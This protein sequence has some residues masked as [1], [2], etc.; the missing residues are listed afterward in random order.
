MGGLVK[1]ANRRLVSHLGPGARKRIAGIMG[2]R[3]LA[4]YRR[5]RADVA[6]VSFPACGR[7]W[8]RVMVG[9]AFQLHY[10][11]PADADVVE[12]HHLAELD[13]CVPNVLVTHDDDAQWKRPDEI[14]RDK[15][16]YRRQRVVLLVRD[17]RDA[18]V[19][20]Y[21]HKTS[22]RGAYDGTLA[23]FLDEP[24]G[25]VASLLAFYDAWAASLDVP[26]ATLVVRY[27][28][29]HA[30]PHEQLRR[31]LAFAGVTGA[32]DATVEAAVEY[33]SFANMRRMEEAGSVASEKLR[34]VRAGDPGSY[35]TRRGTVG[36]HREELTPEQIAH[37]DRLVAASQ[38]S[39]FG[40]GTAGP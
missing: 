38:A 3:A 23:E 1:A 37:L 35:K 6:I 27:E 2:G 17:P 36:G 11:L 4:W 31:V 34:P 21:H 25:S 28:D 7:T 19:S 16:A 15:S 12:L 32:S 26:A 20:L 30:E 39:R 10:G 5:Q 13:R 24:V 9:R 33:G 40:Y 8:L 22:R 14:E 29:L 18:V